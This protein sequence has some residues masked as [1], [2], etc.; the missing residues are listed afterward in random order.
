MG[1]LDSIFGRKSNP[2]GEANNYLNQIPGT[3][4]GGYDPYV[5]EGREAS[6]KTKGIYEGLL[7]DPTGFINKLMESYA[8]S[9]GYQFQRDLL[10]KEMGNTAAAGGIAGTPLDQMNQAQGIQA[11]LSQDQQKYLDNA[12]GV[13]NKGLAGEEGIAGRGFDATKQLTDALAGALNQQGDLAFQNS[14]QNNSD[15]TSQMQ[16]IMKALGGVLRGPGG[17][18]A[19]PMSGSP[20]A[21][22]KNPG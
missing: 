1:L 9:Q 10:S 7:D 15:R 17:G 18:L 16:M 11:L 20:Y 13:F 5:N 21:P 22:W 14:Q 8:P 4:H 19:G 12:L 3:Y 6:G 2:M